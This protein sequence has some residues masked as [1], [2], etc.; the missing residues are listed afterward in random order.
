MHRTGRVKL[1]IKAKLFES[2]PRR[3]LLKPFFFFYLDRDYKLV[4]I[5]CRMVALMFVMKW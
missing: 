4:F 1:K 3:L 5:G 2:H